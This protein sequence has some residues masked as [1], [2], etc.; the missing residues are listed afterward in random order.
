MRPF[1]LPVRQREVERELS[2]TGRAALR[3]A[4]VVVALVEVVDGAERSGG[5]EEQRPNCARDRRS[6]EGRGLR[7][8]RAM[9]E[10]RIRRRGRGE[11]EA[12]VARV[13]VGAAVAVARIDA[14]DAGERIELRAVAERR[15]VA[16]VERIAHATAA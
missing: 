14:G 12:V 15:E 7:S 8:A 16:V 2:H 9:R 10:E 6:S 1:S 4:A 11:A 3:E 13:D 5:V